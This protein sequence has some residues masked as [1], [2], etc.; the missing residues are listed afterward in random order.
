MI[1]NISHQMQV[2]SSFIHKHQSRCWSSVLYFR[3]RKKKDIREMSDRVKQLEGNHTNC[4]LFHHSIKDG[5]CTSYKFNIKPSLCQRAL[6]T[7]GRSKQPASYFW[8]L[9][10]RL[11]WWI[12]GPVC[13]VAVPFKHTKQKGTI[14]IFSALKYTVNCCYILVYGTLPTRHEHF[15]H[16][17][18]YKTLLYYITKIKVFHLSLKVFIHSK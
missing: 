13:N 6:P 2:M 16:F 14:D 8:L 5:A 9:T 12:Y 3:K 17:F 10:G 7:A 4:S 15:V 1:S 11:R 18:L